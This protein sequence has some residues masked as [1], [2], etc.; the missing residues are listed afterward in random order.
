MVARRK[1]SLIQTRSRAQN[2]RTLLDPHPAARHSCRGSRNSHRAARLQSHLSW[3]RHPRLR[4]LAG[5]KIHRRHLP[6]QTQPRPLPFTIATNPSFDVLP[7]CRQRKR[8]SFRT[9]QTDAFAFPIHSDE[10]V[11]LWR[12][13]SLF[14]LSNERRSTWRLAFP[15]S[16]QPS[17]SPATRITAFALFSISSRVVA[18]LDTL[19]RIAAFPCHT[20]PPH[21]HV[22]SSCTRRIT[23]RVFS[24]LPN[25]TSARLI[26][27]SSSPSYP[28][29]RT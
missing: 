18:Q 3:Q 21:Q 24:S 8:P 14:D 16:F 1:T 10:S 5:R 4:H 27:T 19:I 23:S 12:E 20:V 28:P 11:G 9:E 17:T 7:R 6:R 25:D 15:K 13:K 29:P 26:A 2:R 22:P